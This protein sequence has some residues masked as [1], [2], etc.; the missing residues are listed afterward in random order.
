MT[1]FRIGCIIG[2]WVLVFAAAQGF[3]QEEMRVVDSSIFERPVRTSALFAHD[4]HNETAGLDDCSICHHRY[5]DGK[6]MEDE[7]SED[8]TCSEC[9]TI[10]GSGPN[11]SL[12]R[13]FHLNCKGCHLQQGAG[14]ILC[15]QCHQ[16]VPA[17]QASAE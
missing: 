10:D 8:Q 11:P 12:R 7:S 4:M 2:A 14:P 13:A 15:A 6:L 17:D 1:G 16:A 9:H 5:D 3:S